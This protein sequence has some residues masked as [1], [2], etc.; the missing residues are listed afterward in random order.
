M[1]GRIIGD[2]PVLQKRLLF[3]IVPCTINGMEPIDLRK[4]KKI[5]LTAEVSCS[6]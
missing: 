3:L 4:E 5:R 1:P 6:G 2:F